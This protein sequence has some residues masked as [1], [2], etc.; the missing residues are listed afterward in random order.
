MLFAEVGKS[1]KSG[2]D[3]GFKLGYV[4]HVFQVW[5]VFFNFL[6]KNSGTAHSWSL[7]IFSYLMINLLYIINY[8]LMDIFMAKVC[9][10]YVVYCRSGVKG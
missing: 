5:S 7:N 1:V 8:C 4:R 3:G 2:Q 10:G 6:A 9:K